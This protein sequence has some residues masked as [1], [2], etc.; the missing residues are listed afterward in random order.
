MI[1]THHNATSPRDG[2]SSLSRT[3]VPQPWSSLPQSQRAACSAPQI[4]A[5]KCRN[6]SPTRLTHLAT[7]RLTRPATTRLTGLATTRLTL[8]A[9]PGLT[10]L[11]TGEP[12]RTSQKHR[13][14]TQ[15]KCEARLCHVRSASYQLLHT[16]GNAAD[17][18]NLQMVFR[19]TKSLNCFLGF[20]SPHLGCPASAHTTAN[21]A[22]LQRLPKGLATG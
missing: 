16:L 11:A 15:C 19:M 18:V 8:L 6:V 20:T 3:T 13:A 1:V 12:P 5:L 22:T 7:T 17:V 21:F 2:K 4:D 14:G 9:T 10:C